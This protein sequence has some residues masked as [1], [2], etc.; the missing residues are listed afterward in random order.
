M[1]PSREMPLVSVVIPARNVGDTLGAQLSAVA[2]QEVDGLFEVIVA[3]N[4]SQDQTADVVR[5]AMRSIPNLRIVG[6]HDRLGINA[7]RNAGIAAARGQFIMICDGDDLVHPGWIDAHLRC[8]ATNDLCGGALEEQSLNRALASSFGA[9]ALTTSGNPVSGRYLPYPLGGNMAM[10]R[11][12]WEHLGGFDESWSR[13]GTEIEFGWLAQ[14]AG[15]S[16][17]FAA[18]A[19][20]SYRRGG[21][22]WSE[23][24]RQY[25]TQRNL[26]RLYRRHRSNGMPRR[27]RRDALRS[28]AW[29]AVNAPLA[30][31]RQHRHK[32]LVVVSN[33][34]GRLAGSLRWRVGYL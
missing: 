16:L 5:H 14:L 11:Q 20:V 22:A 13:G 29:V 24:R 28:W 9:I 2:A 7:A 19:V 18:D 27:S 31:H 17:G 25:R 23:Y 21:T 1:T 30:L 12:V 33:Q 26:A 3:D 15:F 8:L 32:W 34:A 10:R 6:R 4:D